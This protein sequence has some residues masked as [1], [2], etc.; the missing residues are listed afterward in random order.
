MYK[1]LPLRKLELSK[2]TRC[3]FC[4]QEKEELADAP[5]RNGSWAYF[6][7]ECYSVNAQGGKLGTRHPVG[8]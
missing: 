2:G 6:C 4:Q 7:K 1:D 8:K 5:S 3:D